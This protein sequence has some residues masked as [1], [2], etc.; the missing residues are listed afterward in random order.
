MSVDVYALKHDAV[1]LILL[2]KTEP[3]LIHRKLMLRV[4]SD[5]VSV[6]MLLVCR[7][8][9]NALNRVAGWLSLNSTIDDDDGNADVAVELTVDD[10]C[11]L[12]VDRVFDRD[13]NSLRAM[14]ILMVQWQRQ[15]SRIDG[16]TLDG[17]NAGLGSR[18]D[19]CADDTQC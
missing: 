1:D 15:V 10:C 14:S 8:V 2:R 11:R 13:C 18:S 7:I 9:M 3:D 6:A 19:V 12:R 16:A 5:G 17:W 4:M